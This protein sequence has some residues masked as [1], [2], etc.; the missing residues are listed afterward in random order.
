MNQELIK[1]TTK[2][3]LDV[4]L[5]G[6]ALVVLSSLPKIS[7]HFNHGNHG[8]HGKESSTYQTQYLRK[9]MTR[10]LPFCNE[11]IVLRQG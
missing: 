1:Q 6:T 5:A 2:R 8:N 4:V 10:Y 9:F 3:G 11:G 7:K